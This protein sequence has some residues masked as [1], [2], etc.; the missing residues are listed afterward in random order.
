MPWVG[1]RKEGEKNFT[2]RYFHS[3]TLLDVVEKSVDA[4]FP[5]FIWRNKGLSI[6][7]LVVS[8]LHKQKRPGA[9][10]LASK[11]PGVSTGE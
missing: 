5:I 7:E 2:C 3:C 4:M 9:K 1:G 11:A 8:Q 6:S 10:E